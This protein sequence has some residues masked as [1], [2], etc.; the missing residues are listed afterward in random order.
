MDAYDLPS[1]LDSPSNCAVPDCSVGGAFGAG[2]CR[3]VLYGGYVSVSLATEPPLLQRPFMRWLSLVGFSGP[4]MDLAMQAPTFAL[5]NPALN[6]S[7]WAPQ[8]LL[9]DLNVRNIVMPALPYTDGGNSSA[10]MSYPPPDGMLGCLARKSNL[11]S[12]DWVGAKHFSSGTLGGFGGSTAAGTSGPQVSLALDGDALYGPIY[13]VP[14]AFFDDAYNALAPT[15]TCTGAAACDRIAS[16]C[17]Y[18]VN[19][20]C[21][22]CPLGYWPRGMTGNIFWYCSACTVGSFCNSTLA[23]QLQVEDV[24]FPCPLGT[25][26]SATAQ[27]TCTLC[28]R[29]QQPRSRQPKQWRSSAYRYRRCELS[30]AI[31]FLCCVC[32]ATVLPAKTGTYNGLVGRSDP[33]SC[34]QCPPGSANPWKGGGTLESSCGLCQPGTA[35]G[36]P[37][38]AM[39]PQCPLGSYADQPES[40]TCTLCPSGRFGTSAGANSSAMC[41]P[42]PPSAPSS[43]AGSSSIQQ[44]T[45]PV[46]PDGFYVALST[47]TVCSTPCPLGSSCAAGHV[48]ACAAGSFTDRLAQRNC[49]ACGAGRVGVAVGSASEG[50]CSSCPVSTYS[51]SAVSGSCT[52]CPAGYVTAAAGSTSSL[53][54]QI[55]ADCLT[56]LTLA[57]QSSTSASGSGSGSPTM[58]SFCPLA[59]SAPILLSSLLPGGLAQMRAYLQRAERLLQTNASVG[60]NATVVSAAALA[61]VYA[62]YSPLRFSESLRMAAFGSDATLARFGATGLVAAEGRDPFAVASVHTEVLSAAGYAAIISSFL[63][64]AFVPLLLYRFLP[65][66]AVLILDQ[67]SLAHRIRIGEAVKKVPTQFGAMVTWSFLWVAALVAILLATQTNTVSTVELLPPSALSSQAGTAVADWEIT[68]RVHTGET[69]SELGSWCNNAAS[70]S[71]LSQQTGFSS[72]FTLATS[73]AT[74]GS[75]SLAADCLDCGLSASSGL[76]SFT[77]P[78]S[79]QLIEWELWVNSAQPDAWTRRYGVL[80]QLPGRLID[81]QSSLEFSALESYF[82]DERSSSFNKGVRSGADAQRSG[83]ELSFLSFSVV[84]PQSAATFTASSTVAVTFSLQRSDVLLRTRLSDKQTL[85]QLVTL[86]A[87]SVVSLFSIFAI[88]FRLTEA[89]LIKRCG[90]SPG[91]IHSGEAATSASAKRRQL[92]GDILRESRAPLLEGAASADA[93]V[94]GF[95]AAAIV[96]TRAAPLQ[97]SSIAIDARH[98]G[99]LGD[100][101]M[102][103]RQPQQQLASPS[104][105]DARSRGNSQR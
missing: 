1:A 37:G 19:G 70:G 20:V 56:A 53:A 31:L 16:H 43:P 21:Q 23:Q 79:A 63:L 48:T 27:A 102:Q 83:F 62:S 87:S 61:S 40:Y 17:P 89:H 36:V 58:S 69:V 67:F 26:Q 24:P 81:A 99:A 34:L 38:T 13:P 92:D 50:G 15:I 42:C 2:G 60:S 101:E 95:G 94:A 51:S 5:W 10:Q 55:V 35:S 82:S 18:I 91:E 75:C 71:L 86:I 22:L 80:T 32:V 88:A 49:T 84:E 105:R 100:M 54:C 85:L 30:H 59:A 93:S 97:L 77:F 12:L 8:N 3:D 29:G 47:D 45:G 74:A 64:L 11:K 98:D 65:R 41:E 14:P 25:F 76:A 39:C 46:C 9:C 6:R 57:D 66:R 68:L 78:S 4:S 72:A 33:A 90:L 52:P 44:C 7:D 28:P 96:P 103:Y 73:A 104:A